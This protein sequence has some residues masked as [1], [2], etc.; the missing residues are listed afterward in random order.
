[1]LLSNFNQPVALVGFHRPVTISGIRGLAAISLHCESS[2]RGST[3]GRDSSVVS[4]STVV[5]TP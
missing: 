5:Q 2:G 3:P 4:E 1:M